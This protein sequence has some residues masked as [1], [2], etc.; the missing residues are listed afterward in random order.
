MYCNIVID[1]VLCEAAAFGM[2]VAC[3]QDLVDCSTVSYN[4]S[5]VY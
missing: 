1:I 3:P 2:L 4:E 5:A